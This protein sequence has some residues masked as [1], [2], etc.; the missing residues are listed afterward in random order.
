MLSVRPHRLRS[1]TSGRRRHSYST[2][3]VAY[4]VSRNRETVRF[5]FRRYQHRTTGKYDSLGVST[6][7]VCTESTF[8]SYCHTFRNGSAI[9]LHKI[10]KTFFTYDNSFFGRCRVSCKFEASQKTDGRSRRADYGCKIE[11]KGDER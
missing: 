10:L 5:F 6:Y 11:R 8:I 1:A 3:L 2:I 9:I 7:C 4:R